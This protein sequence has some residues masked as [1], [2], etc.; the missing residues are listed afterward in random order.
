MVAFSLNYN[1]TQSPVWAVFPRSRHYPKCKFCPTTQ[2]EAA[3]CRQHLSSHKSCLDKEAILATSRGESQNASRARIPAPSD[4]LPPSFGCAPALGSKQDCR[5]SPRT[6]RAAALFPTPAQCLAQLP[7]TA[8]ATLPGHLGCARPTHPLGSATRPSPGAPHSSSRPAPRWL[9][10]R[11]PRPA[12]PQSSSL[13]AAL[14]RH[15]PWAAAA[16]GNRGAAAESR[17]ALETSREA[18]WAAR[19]AP[20]GWRCRGAGSREG[21]GGAA[22]P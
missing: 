12:Q 5:D 18:A 19:A 14:G 6:R 8:R 2:A 13:P 9:L 21:P 11:V 7:L 22:P 17:R 1:F 16:L 10:P 15:S 3:C 4:A 20:A